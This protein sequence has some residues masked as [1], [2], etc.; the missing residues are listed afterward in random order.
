MCCTFRNSLDV[1]AQRFESSYRGQEE[2]EGEDVGSRHGGRLCFYQHN[3]SQHP[4]SRAAGQQGSSSPRDLTGGKTSTQSGPSPQYKLSPSVSRNLCQEILIV[5]NIK[6]SKCLARVELPA[7][8]RTSV[9][10]QRNCLSAFLYGSELHC[11]LHLPTVNL[12]EARMTQQQPASVQY[13]RNQNGGCEIQ[14]F[15]CQ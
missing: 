7:V 14:C 8:W 2:E 10:H 5:E 9:K 11:S 6:E 1:K 4:G 12:M 15:K 3:R 13:Q